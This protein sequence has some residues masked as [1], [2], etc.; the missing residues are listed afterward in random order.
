MGD[1]FSF[2]VITELF[3]YDVIVTGVTEMIETT[4]APFQQFI[5]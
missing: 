5:P 2:Q 1:W 4:P 3:L